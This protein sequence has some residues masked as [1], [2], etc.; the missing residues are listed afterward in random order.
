MSSGTNP[1]GYQ[2]RSRLRAPRRQ[3]S[4]VMAKSRESDPLE[5]PLDP[6]TTQMQPPLS[7]TVDDDDNADDERWDENE[8][9]TRAV[10]GTSEGEDEFQIDEQDEDE[11]MRGCATG[12][13][14]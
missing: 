2:P 8:A 12:A 1:A 5:T 7:G 3:R 13:N 6:D 4:S 11:Q 14:R 9:P 10:S